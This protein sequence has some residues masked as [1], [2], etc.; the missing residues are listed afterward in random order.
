MFNNVPLSGLGAFLV[1]AAYLLHQVRSRY[2][3][4]TAE[5]AVR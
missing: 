2:A 4:V 5:E 3:D 1:V